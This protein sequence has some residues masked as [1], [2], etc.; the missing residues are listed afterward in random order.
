MLGAKNTRN[1]MTANFNWRFHRDGSLP[2]SDAIW[3]FGSN[4]A[5]RHGLG[6]ALVARERFAAVPGV[7][8][9]RTGRAYAI[10]TKDGRGGQR[11][12]DPAAT[13]PLQEAR[14][15]I[16]AFIAYAKAH[17]ELSFF[18]TRIGC[19]HAAFADAQIAP[20][21]HDAPNNCSFADE[22]RPL[23]EASLRPGANSARPR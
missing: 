1:P 5:G 4:L 18:V 23:L 8:A 21:F 6:A 9:G 7:G 10:P 12:T 11:L 19:G 13:L 20:L 17:P 22:W 3:V 2:Q 16:R 14:E 15:N